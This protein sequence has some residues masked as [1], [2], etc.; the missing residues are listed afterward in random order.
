MKVNHIWINELIQIQETTLH[1]T[2]GDGSKA[3]NPLHVK[4][5]YLLVP[6]NIL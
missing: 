2:I 1:Y 5:F 6:M 4:K 3:N